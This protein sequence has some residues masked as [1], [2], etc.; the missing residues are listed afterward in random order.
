MIECPSAV[1]FNPWG[2]AKADNVTND[3]PHSR[4]ERLTGCHYFDDGRSGVE[5]KFRD[6]SISQKVCVV[7]V[8]L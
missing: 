4:C 6:I 5:Q 2:R 7:F 3:Q 1:E 8:L